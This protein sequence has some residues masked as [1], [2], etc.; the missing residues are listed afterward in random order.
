MRGSWTVLV[1][2]VLIAMFYA[3]GMGRSGFEGKDERR[4]SQVGKEIGTG[5][6][7]FVM[8]YM[9]ELY[10]DKP[11]LFFWMEALSFRILGVSPLAARIPLLVT[12]MLALVFCYLLMLRLEGPR[13]AL[14]GLITL[15]LAF[16]FFWASRWVRLDMPMCAF[17]FG[18]FWAS[19]RIL[20]PR[21]GER[22]AGIGWAL[23]AWTMA[24]LAILSKGPG[25][26]SWLGAI[27][28]FAVVMRDR[29]VIAKHY[30][31]LGLPLM[32]AMVLA[33]FIPAALMGGKDYYGPMI[34]T[35]VVERLAG[36]VRHEKPFW[37]F[38][39][40]LLSDSL[41][42][43]LL[44][45]AALWWA[46]KGDGG[47]KG[48]SGDRRRSAIYLLCWL[49]FNLIFY[50]IPQGKRGQYIL[51]LYPAVA[52]LV[53][54]LVD[55]ALTPG[56]RSPRKLVLGHLWV[57]VAVFTLGGIAAIFWTKPLS[58]DFE[59]A[60]PLMLRL[61]IFLGFGVGGALAIWALKTSRSKLAFAAPAA[62]LG[63][64]YAALF[65]FYFPLNR[66]DALPREVAA[67]LNDPALADRP[68]AFFGADDQFALYMKG[69]P[70][71]LD[72]PEQVAAFVQ[73]RP[74]AYVL[75]TEKKFKKL[76]KAQGQPDWQL[77]GQWKFPEEKTE[78]MLYAVNPSEVVAH[79]ESE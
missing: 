27:L 31:L 4:Y 57:I 64:V 32:M 44:L 71:E 55:A 25:V 39:P 41:P 37:Y 61:S 20:F 21:E 36:A 12:A 7:F 59:A 75:A 18:A 38:F 46:W 58:D 51:P 30:P 3:A 74:D 66:N 48:G 19:T 1:V 22:E 24:A 42:A 76:V 5:A 17:T 62:G 72:E 43:G 34:G 65:L 29:S 15:A 16:R 2:F 9:G 28:T 50:S 78:L 68:V 11:P 69:V 6:D 52:L 47:V 26:I 54:R 13:V 63:L 79:S 70:R 23:I 40:K 14:I 35:H 77:V 8:H 53:A 49:G 56:E 45:P 67:K 60:P 33:W 10:P 73:K